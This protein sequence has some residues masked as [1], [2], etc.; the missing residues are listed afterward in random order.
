MGTP[1][2]DDETVTNFKHCLPLY[3]RG[4]AHYTIPRHFTQFNCDSTR[5]L[6]KQHFLRSEITNNGFIQLIVHVNHQLSS[7]IV[8][9]QYRPVYST[10]II[11][12]AHTVEAGEML[13]ERSTGKLPRPLKIAYI[14]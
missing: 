4:M 7:G 2:S 14:I 5:A 13:L 9:I 3:I 11:A 8:N 1:C 12:I 10:V 6:F